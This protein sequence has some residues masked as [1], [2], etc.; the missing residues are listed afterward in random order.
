MDILRELK[1]NH[2]DFFT[3]KTYPDKA[4]VCMYV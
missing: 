3:Y 1:H 2:S 4:L